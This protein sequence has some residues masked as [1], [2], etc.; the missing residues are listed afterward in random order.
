MAGNYGDF[1]A[2]TVRQGDVAVVA[3]AWVPLTSSGSVGVTTNTLPMS[4]RRHIR[5]AIKADAGG[6]LAVQ[7]VTKN[8]DG[9]FTTPTTAS[10]KTSTVFPGNSIVIEPIGDAV[11]VY[12]RLV[13]KKG[14][15]L[16]SIRVIVTEFS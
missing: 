2:R 12:G 16:N 6:A 11:Q 3:T 14:F 10:V 13:K 7:Y 1:V 8:A 9:T 5:Y 4:A 15:N